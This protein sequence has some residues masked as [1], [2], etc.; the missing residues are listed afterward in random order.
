MIKMGDSNFDRLYQTCLNMIM[1]MG[2]DTKPRDFICREIGPCCLTLTNIDYNILTNPVRKAS[3]TF[4]A[5]EFLWIMLAREDVEWIRHYSGKIAQYSDDG[6]TFFGPYG[7]KIMDQLPYVINKLKED[8]WSRQAVLTI[9]RENPPKVKDVPCTV[10][11]QFIQRPI[12]RLNLITYMRS[13]DVWLGLPYDVHNFTSLQKIVASL[14]GI[15]PGIFTLIQGSLHAYEDNFYKIDGAMDC[16]LEPDP[17][18]TPDS[19]VKSLNELF[20]ELFMVN[21]LHTSMAN[22][23]QVFEVKTHGLTDPL[24]SQKMDWLVAYWRKKN[25]KTNTQ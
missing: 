24:L 15:S 18:I 22:N 2:T 17:M 25:E 10:T 3:L 6:V 16:S 1:T 5:A 14:L 9:W 21:L 4:M 23:H 20:G 13:Q 19:T 12:G 11:M 7:P 8:P